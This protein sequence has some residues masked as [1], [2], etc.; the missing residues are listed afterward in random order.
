MP[1][2]LGLGRMKVA[3]V[4]LGEMQQDG[5]GL[6]EAGRVLVGVR[7]VDEAR[8]HRVRVHLHEARGELIALEDVD[9]PRVVVQTEFLQENGDLHTVRSAE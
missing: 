1:L 9:K 3:A 6:K 4:L 7:M 5:I 8:D 2:R